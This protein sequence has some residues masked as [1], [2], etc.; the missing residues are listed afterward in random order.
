MQSRLMSLVEA[1]ANV[2]VGYGVAVGTQILIFPL[3]GLQMTLAQN[4]MMG[5][6]FTVFSI[7]RSFALRRAFEAVR[8]RGMPARAEAQASRKSLQAGQT[9]QPIERQRH[10]NRCHKEQRQSQQCGQ[11]HFRTSPGRASRD[12]DPCERG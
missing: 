1:I 4:L 7:A 6:I 5:A 10:R 8:F 3:F 2:V 12:F 9:D 11:E